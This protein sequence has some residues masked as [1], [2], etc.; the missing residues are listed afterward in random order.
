MKIKF[1]DQDRLGCSCEGY[2]YKREN[3]E[4]SVAG[5]VT[6][7]LNNFDERGDLTE[8]ESTIVRSCK[9]IDAMGRLVEI[10][11][12]KGILSVEEVIVIAGLD[13]DTEQADHHLTPPTP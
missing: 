12:A 13:D 3:R 6:S 5:Y 9:A 2:V 10:M 7:T 1:T 4:Q 11:A 8:S